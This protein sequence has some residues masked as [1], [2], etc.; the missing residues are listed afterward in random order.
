MRKIITMIFTVALMISAVTC[1][2]AI[3]Y[4]SIP[5]SQALGSK[6]IALGTWYDND[7]NSVLRVENGYINGAEIIS[8]GFMG[9]TVAFYKFRVKD[10]DSYRDIELQTFGSYDGDHV[11]LVMND[12]K[13]LRQTQQ[14][15]YY[16]SIGGIY[17]GMPKSK[18]MEFYGEPLN[19]E[20]QP[21]QKSSTWTYNGFEVFFNHDIVTGITI[22]KSG[23]RRFDL[24]GLSAS[25][26]IEDFERKYETKVGRRGALNIG[27]GEIIVVND[28]RA[29]LQMFTPGCVI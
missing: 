5:I 24:S 11:M 6:G 17:L 22:Y 18:V 21:S 12:T 3:D 25:S 13:V 26:S 8:V 9:D 20:N 29:T 10:G 16:E 19:A 15:K 1:Q 2:A 28:G 14:P 4:Q 7:G 23:D 27:H